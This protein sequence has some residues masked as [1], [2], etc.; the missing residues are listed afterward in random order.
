MS[1]RNT[2]GCAFSLRCPYVQERCRVEAPP[3][4]PAAAP[5]H[6][7]ACFYPLGT[8]ENRAALDANLTA[9]LHQAVASVQGAGLGSG[10]AG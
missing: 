7:F 5:G 2:T 8:S 3:L 4:T 1:C 10:E 9:D 6:R